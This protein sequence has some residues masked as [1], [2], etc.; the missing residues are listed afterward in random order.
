MPAHRTTDLAA[1]AGLDPIALQARVDEVLA[2]PLYWFPVRHH[3]PTVARHL[4]AA[5][6]SR[7]PSL[8]F[9]E[10]PSEANDLV[11]FVTDAKTAPPVAIYSSYRDDGN[12]LGLN[13]V[14]SPALDIP[15]RFA[16]WYPLTSYSP[17]YVA[18]KTAASIGA[19]VVFID[20]PHHALIR[21]RIALENGPPKSPPPASPDDDRLITASTFYQHLADAAG[22]KTWDEAWD[23][24]FEDPSPTDF[25]AFRRELATF[26]AAAR[27]TSDPS[28]EA[29]EGTVARERHFLETIRETLDARKIPAEK[30]AVVCG[31]FHLF[32]DRDDPERPP[33]PPE[34]TVYTTVVPY[35]YFRISEMA[36]YGAGNRAPRFYQT[37]FDLAAAGRGGDIALEH[38]I[39]VL[40]RV[41][42]SGEAMSTADAIAATH[43]AAM[44]GR[45]RGRSHATLDDIYD[46]LLT[47]C[48]KGVPDDEGAKLLEAM[49]L[50]GIGNRIGKVTPAIGR[51]PIVGD[52]H[53]QIA[54]LGLGEAIEQEKALPLRLDLREPIDARR[55]AFLHRLDFLEVPFAS[56]AG[57]GGDF[58]GTIFREDWR[59]KWDP[60][61][62]P[63]LVE[64]NLYGDT[65]EAAALARLRESIARTGAS[66]GE[67]CERLH[68]A[69]SMDLPDLVRAAEDACGQAIDVD[70]SFVSLAK[71]LHHL[72]LIDRYAVFRGLRRDVVED[73]LARC[74]DR[75]CFAL[76][77][78]AA[79]PEDEQRGVVEALV[80]VADL[81]QRND[82]DR[83]DRDLF[84]EA[85]HR[86]ADETPSPYLRGAFLGLLC[87]IRELPADALA[88][89]V[90][91]LAR[92]GPDRMMTAGD[93]LDGMLTVSRTSIL[94]GADA[95]V[96]AVD[97]LLE[98]AEWDPFLVM[99]PR[100]RAAFERL[101]EAQ[102][103][104]LAAVVARLR[105]LD[106]AEDVRDLPIGL[107][108]TAL[109]ARIDAAVAETLKD[110]PL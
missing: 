47:C 32:L 101:S 56:V 73:L 65:V 64:Q 87:E 53:D 74:Y 40:R 27:A 41:R 7:R 79:V 28:A 42:R 22:Y 86:A 6:L 109:V 99:L 97:E 91:G 50:A 102:R 95:L 110:W 13:G 45:L 35:S 4:R 10:G 31:G 94:L 37:C 88:A 72:E 25:E 81:V 8:V 108:A 2:L 61:T 48:C 76:P 66:A 1:D 89:E 63:S 19:E 57:T 44:L 67:S 105:G 85:A 17:E 49:D 84:A 5:L 54:A 90:S 98:A 3:S 96:S 77:H 24:L 107:G 29:V 68:R 15:S 70:P 82:P 58:S 75:A 92:A 39:D 106:T 33:E 12:V 30:A 78:S 34:G 93:L 60:K 14:V 83:F 43:H 51:L 16:V 100:L 38:A 103:D 36:G 21:P 62:E 55:S 20:L 80:S 104:S 26:C 71:A 46:A 52:F 69:A 11:R 59:L 9:I 18:L 23:T